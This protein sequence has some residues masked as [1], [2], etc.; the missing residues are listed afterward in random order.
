M[1]KKVGCSCG[2]LFSGNANNRANAGFS[3]AN[4]NN[5]PSNTN[6]NISSHLYFSIWVKKYMGA[7][8]LPLGKKHNVRKELVGTPVVWA[9]E[10]PD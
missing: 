1:R 6:A 7:A 10:R 3:Y 4:S 8:A 9:T 5:T 2:V